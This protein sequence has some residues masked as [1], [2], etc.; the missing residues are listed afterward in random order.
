MHECTLYQIEC[1]AADWRTAAR[2]V[3]D[4]LRHPAILFDDV[5]DARKQVFEE[6][7]RRDVRAGELTWES[8]L[9]P[10]HPLGR[11]VAADRTGRIET[12]A[13]RAFFAKHYCAGNMAIGFCG[14]V[15]AAECRAEIAR[16]FAG[17]PSGGEPPVDPVVHPWVG[18]GL[19]AGYPNEPSGWLTTGYHLTATDLRE[20]AAVQMLAAYLAQP[21]E[22]GVGW[23]TLLSSFAVSLHARRDGQRLEFEATVADPLQLEVALTAVDTAIAATSTPNANRM[24][25]ARADCLA[26]LSA[27]T[28]EDLASA[29][30][31]CWLARRRGAALSDW[32]AALDAVTAADLTHCAATQLLPS[33]RY[34]VSRWPLSR[35]DVRWF[36]I[37]LCALAALALDGLFGFRV[38]RR[39]RRALFARSTSAAAAAPAGSAAQPPSPIRPGNADDL[40]RGIQQF[41]EDEQR[42]RD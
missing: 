18:Q 42:G 21:P 23:P 32:L 36:S 37:L 27:G 30:L 20:C 25:A 5:V 3:A 41:Y 8:L 40:I 14:P 28:S 34:V 22:R 29:M 13:L 12:D 7:A 2:W 1:A 10:G 26:A 9:F 39:A 4:K 6:V 24:A 16:A 31:Q 35:P 33:R 19:W 17:L 15:P 38:L 11:A